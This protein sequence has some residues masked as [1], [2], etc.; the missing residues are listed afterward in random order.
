LVGIVSVFQ[1]LRSTL[2]AIPFCEFWDWR[3]DLGEDVY[4]IIKAPQLTIHIRKYF[5]PNAHAHNILPDR[6]RD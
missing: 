1:N 4:V 3:Y 6:E 2:T 5:V